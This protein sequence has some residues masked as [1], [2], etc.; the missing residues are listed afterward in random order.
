DRRGG[1]GPPGPKKAPHQEFRGGDCF[2][3]RLCS[4]HNKTYEESEWPDHKNARQPHPEK[5][6]DRHPGDTQFGISIGKLV[7]QEA[8]AN[9]NCQAD[10]PDDTCK[11]RE[12]LAFL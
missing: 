7:K 9:A 5:E 10:K 8:N 2:S 12:K 3:D 1:G 11:C 6:R 4:S